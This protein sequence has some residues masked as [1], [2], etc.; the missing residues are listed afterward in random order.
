MIVSVGQI[1][2]DNIT[3][4]LPGPP[5]S[6]HPRQDEGEDQ[7]DGGH[8]GADRRGPGFR[9]GPDRIRDRSGHRRCDHETPEWLIHIDPY[10]YIKE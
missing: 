10:T 1:K 2:S 3:G 4:R 8:P 9:A 5:M 7:K 6:G